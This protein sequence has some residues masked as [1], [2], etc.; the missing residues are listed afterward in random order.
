MRRP[1]CVSVVVITCLL[2]AAPACVAGGAEPPGA[3]PGSAHAAFTHTP[4][5]RHID[6]HADV[7]GSQSIQGG[8][9]GKASKIS[10]MKRQPCAD[11]QSAKNQTGSVRAGAGHGKPMAKAIT[12]AAKPFSMHVMIE[13]LKKTD[14]IGILTKLTLRSDARDLMAMIKTHEKNPAR[15]SLQALRARFDGLILKVL[16]LLGSDPKLSRDIYLARNCI[17]KSLLGVKG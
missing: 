12:P 1:L 2:L 6:N 11:H 3:L 16:A 9:P 13:R 4:V 7:T 8:K 10:G 5:I 17:W 15:Y 14:A